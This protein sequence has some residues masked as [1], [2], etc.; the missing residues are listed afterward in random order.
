MRRG[1]VCLLCLSILL[2][3][4]PATDTFVAANGTA[5]TTY[6]ANWTTPK[7]VWDIQGNAAHNT[8]PGA[9]GGITDAAY[10]TAFWNADSFAND[11]TGS[12]K[13]VSLTASIGYVGVALRADN[14]AGGNA[15]GCHTDGVGMVVNKL[16][17][18]SYNFV[19]F[20]LV[21]AAPNDILTFTVRGT[22]LTCEINGVIKITR[23]D[24]SL[25]AGS[26][27]LS[28]YG[29]GASATNFR[30]DSFRLPMIRVF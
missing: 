8:I 18:G 26:V 13:I 19:A 7:G 21:T 1:L 17:N 22:T 11:Q 5:L 4:L 20:A 9:P 30:G 6:S 2:A 15:Y 14:V 24:S 28:A 10:A 27:G 23:T 3:A 16:I 25:S 29:D 12:V